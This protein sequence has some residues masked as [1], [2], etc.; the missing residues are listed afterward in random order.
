M[1]AERRTWIGGNWKMNGTKSSVAS[2]VDMLNSAVGEVPETCDVVVAP[3]AL[4]IPFVQEN[5]NGRIAVAT[6]I[7]SASPPPR[8]C[9]YARWH[10]HDGERWH[11]SFL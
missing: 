1:A 10:H 6:T 8:R 3:V 7:T 4:H 2:L 5:L 9:S 11:W